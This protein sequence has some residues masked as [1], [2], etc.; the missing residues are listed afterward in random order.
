MD[1]VTF[2]AIVVAVLAVGLILG[3]G[4][5]QSLCRREV[6]KHLWLLFHVIDAEPAA[7]KIRLD[8]LELIKRLEL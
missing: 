6:R 3:W 7:G 1:W 4:I 5:G 8:I 2:S